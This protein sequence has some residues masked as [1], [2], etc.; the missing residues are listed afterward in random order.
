MIHV[1]QNIKKA[2]QIPRFTFMLLNSI[3]IPVR[4]AVHPQ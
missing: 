2:G 4:R 3:V 1:I